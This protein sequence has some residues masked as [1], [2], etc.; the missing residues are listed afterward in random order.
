MNGKKISYSKTKTKTK[1]KDIF[2]S[3]VNKNKQVKVMAEQQELL[4]V[5]LSISSFISCYLL[6]TT[7]ISGCFSAAV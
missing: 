7:S 3:S 5:L 2:L 4:D 1:L 6:A